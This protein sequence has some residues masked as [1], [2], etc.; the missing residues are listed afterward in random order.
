MT[1]SCIRINTV[2][3]QDARKYETKSDEDI[4]NNSCYGAIDGDRCL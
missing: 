2:L 1:I 4:G 3:S